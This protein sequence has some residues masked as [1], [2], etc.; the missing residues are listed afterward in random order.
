MPRH[1]IHRLGPIVLAAA[2]SLS[3][4]GKSPPGDPDSGSSFPDAGRGE[5][6]SRPDP[7]EAGNAGKNPS[8]SRTPLKQAQLEDLPP[9]PGSAL[10]D[11][12]PNVR[13][14]YHDP[15]LLDEALRD[16]D[17]NVRIHALETW[18]QHPGVSLDPVTY[19]LVDPD[20]SVRARAQELF[21]QELTQR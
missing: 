9:W 5:A 21:E 18:A 14:N 2:L 6:A 13:T 16:P 11:S 4:C 7:L 17:P 1:L 19:A 3:A 8:A 10:P 12:D 20:E 15:A